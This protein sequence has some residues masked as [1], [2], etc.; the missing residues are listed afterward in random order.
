MWHVWGEM[1]YK[2][3]WWENASGRDNWEG[4]DVNDRITLKWIFKTQ[5]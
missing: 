5:D 4:L 1:R 2:Q 3:L